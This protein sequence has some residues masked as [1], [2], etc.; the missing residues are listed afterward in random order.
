MDPDHLVGYCC[1]GGADNLL[2]AVASLNVSGKGLRDY[3]HDCAE[4]CARGLYQA[5]RSWLTDVAEWV[6]T[7]ED[8]G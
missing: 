3:R 2:C 1:C 5:F 7:G 4:V 6:A 8:Q